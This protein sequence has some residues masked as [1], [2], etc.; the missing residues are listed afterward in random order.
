METKINPYSELKGAIRDVADFPKPGILFRD[1]TPL[2][3]Q[4]DLFKKIVE[5]I[6]QPFLNNRIDYVVGIEARGFLLASA[7]AY[8]LQAGL[9]PVRKKGKLPCK[10]QS[11]TYNLEYGQDTLEI[12]DDAI[13]NK[14]LKNG[15][16]HVLIV[17][18]VLA[19]GETAKCAAQLVE[20]VGG[21]VVGIAFLIELTPLKGREK[22]KHYPLHSLITY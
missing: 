19:T 11:M 2:L 20:R 1:I 3:A 16:N 17:D 4:H 7:I 5:A 9:I 6:A 10:R 18:D 8:K 13:E 21:K 14:K 12:H 15:G 22:I